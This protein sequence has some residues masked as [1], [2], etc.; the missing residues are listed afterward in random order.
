MTDERRA[1]ILAVSFGVHYQYQVLASKFAGDLPPSIEWKQPL[2]DRLVNKKKKRKLVVASPS[3]NKADLQ[4][5]FLF[6]PDLVGRYR[7][8]QFVFANQGQN[9]TVVF[10]A[11]L[12]GISS[13]FS[14]ITTTTTTTTTITTTTTTTTRTQ[15]VNYDSTLGCSSIL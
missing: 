10:A 2:L 13:P 12:T 8:W 3:I 5:R 9:R 15:Y 4:N 7:D 14:T 1:M 11:G 6:G